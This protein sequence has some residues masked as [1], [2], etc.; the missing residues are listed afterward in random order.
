M[1]MFITTTANARADLIQRYV[2]DTTGVN[3][4]SG[5]LSLGDAGP[6][7]NGTAADF[8]DLAA[9]AQMLAAEIREANAASTA[10]AA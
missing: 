4:G 9:A 1:S 10:E 2:H 6:Y 3:A 8:E 5:W 7:I